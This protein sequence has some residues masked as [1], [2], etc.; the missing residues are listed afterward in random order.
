MVSIKEVHRE[1]AGGDI[2]AWRSP[3]FLFK[4]KWQFPGNTR[5]HVGGGR[6]R[7]TGDTGA[8][9]T[10][11]REPGCTTRYRDRRRT[12]RNGST[13][14]ANWR[15]TPSIWH[16]NP[17]IVEAP[18]GD[19]RLVGNATQ[20]M[21]TL[22][23]YWRPISQVFVYSNLTFDRSIEGTGPVVAFLEYHAAITWRA[24]SHLVPAFEFV[25]STNTIAGRRNW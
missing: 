8:V 20:V 21:P 14:P 15:G 1:C 23:W 4:L 12:V 6:R 13:A 10:A 3:V 18:T 5:R 19:S 9:S 11:S 2:C 16:C 7:R 17:G 25:A 22:L 24:T